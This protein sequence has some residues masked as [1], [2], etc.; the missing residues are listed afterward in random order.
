[1]KAGKCN[2]NEVCPL[3]ARSSDILSSLSS[4]CWKQ[5]VKFRDCRSSFKSLKTQITPVW[6]KLKSIVWPEGKEVSCKSLMLILFVHAHFIIPGHE[7]LD[8]QKSGWFP[9]FLSEIML[10]SV[11]SCFWRDQHFIWM[12]PLQIQNISF[13]MKNTFH[14]VCLVRK[15]QT[16]SSQSVFL[17][18]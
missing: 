2:I 14:V 4:R 11:E 6:G 1:M 13:E 5:T 18:K 16:L 15:H 9:S 3:W 17:H 8:E 10:C 7:A 12:Q